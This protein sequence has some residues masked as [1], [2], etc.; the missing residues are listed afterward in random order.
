MNEKLICLFGARSMVGAHL[1]PML[2]SRG[3]AIHGYTRKDPK[4]AEQFPDIIWHQ[5]MPSDDF[6]RSPLCISMMPIWELPGYFRQMKEAGIKRLI[7]FSST[8]IFAKAESSD[9]AERQLAA[10]LARAE[11]KI[12]EWAERYKV[13]WTILRPTMIYDEGKDKNISA[14][15]SFI[16]KYGFFPIVGRGSGLRSPVYAGDLAD[17]VIKLLEM[18]RSWINYYNLSGGENL[19][20]NDMVKRIFAA[21]GEEPMILHLP[22]SLLTYAIKAA[23]I[24]PQFRTLTPGLAGRMQINQ[25]FSHDDAVS[26]FG[27]NPRAFHPQFR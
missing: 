3:Y 18:E 15:A 13:Q 14:V 20:Y 2:R 9:P 11:D 17:A 24:L 5:I 8:S 6:A 21:L 25:V 23:R 27:Y 26:D 19:S 16:R 10:R 7:V 12:A 22:Q 1:I 4:T